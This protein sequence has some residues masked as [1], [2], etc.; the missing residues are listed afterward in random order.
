MPGF[1]IHIAVGKEYIKKHEN[2]IKD[3]DEFI[4]GIVAP[5]LISILN[6][7]INKSITHYGKLHNKD[8]IKNLD[9]F[10]QNDKVD[11]NNDYWKGYFIHLIT[12]YCF[13]VESFKDETLEIKKN[14][15]SFYYDYDCLNKTL[16][17][18]YNIGNIKDENV[19]KYIKN[20]DG[21]PKYLKEEKV[22]KFIE[23]LSDISIAEQI[24]L[25]RKKNKKVL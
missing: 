24:E 6:K 11:I 22:I 1:I 4:K 20:I 3:V 19:S 25:I 17:K 14:N 18:K 12:D 7:E 21:M 23:K 5:D 15:D 13:Y 2:E 8:Y 9:T 16:T 10:L